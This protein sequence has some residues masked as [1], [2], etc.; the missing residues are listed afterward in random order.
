VAVVLVRL[1]LAIQRRSWGHGGTGQRL[2]FVFGWLL[3][4]VLGLGAGELVAFLDSSRDGLGDLA[5]VV[6][7]TVVFLGWV[8]IPVV[9]PGITDQTV[10]PARL[11]QYPISAGQQVAG[12]LLGALI[13]PTALFTFLLAAG[14]TFAAGASASAR[15]F[16]LVAAVVFTVLCVAASRSVQA[17]LA[18]VLQSRRGRDVAIAATGVLALGGYLISRS[19]NNLAENLLELESA[20]TEAVLSWLPPGAIG[21]GVIAVRDDQ[22]GSGLAH[23]LVALAGIGVAVAAWAWAI[24]RR[25]RGTSARS[26]G[27]GGQPTSGQVS[28][29]PVPLSAWRPSPTLASASQQAR[30]FF[31]RSPRAVQSAALPAVMGIVLAHTSV[32]DGGLVIA[33]V[34][35]VLVALMAT[36]F[37]LFAFDD[38]GFS[39]LIATATPWRPVLVGKALVGLLIVGPVL[40]ALVAVEAAL[41]D[42]WSTA[43]AAFAVG[44]SVAL[45][46]IGVGAVISVVTPLN[47]VHP[48]GPS[49]R[50]VLVGVMAGL[51]AVV[52]V[53]GVAGFAWVL[54]SDQADPTWMA[55]GAVPVAGLLAWALLRYAGGRLERDPWRV[56]DMLRA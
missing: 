37:N 15:V 29:A 53:L 51:A 8:L 1:K 4:L 55:L 54:L 43:V 22:W 36:A 45:V 6:L 48:A 9:L 10:D 13:A 31:F 34:F 41:N 2:A 19:A 27:R 28:L 23:L 32:A 26:A 44:A 25:V 21:Q 20:P 30:Y 52:L 56:H 12:L 16:V 24:R 17:L 33:A 50:R 35:F 38:T 14:G 7:L 18:G 42:L 40:A 3:A 11:E 47:Q 39:Y 49:R 46:V 5:L